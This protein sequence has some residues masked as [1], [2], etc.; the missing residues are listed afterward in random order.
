MLLVGGVVEGYRMRRRTTFSGPT[1]WR[2]TEKVE[3]Q[4]EVEDKI[5]VTTQVFRL[6]A[7]NYLARHESGH[8]TP[9]RFLGPWVQAEMHPSIAG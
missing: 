6:K 4:A 1:L 8:S 5:K 9:S 3:V 2:G 7:I